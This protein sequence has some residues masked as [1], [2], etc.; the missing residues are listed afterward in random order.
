MVSRMAASEAGAEK[1]PPSRAAAL[2]NPYY[3][4]ELAEREWSKV[5][6]RREFVR[7]N[8]PGDEGAN[9]R[10]P[11]ADCLPPGGGNDY[12]GLALSGG[13]IRSATFC[14]GVCQH[15][16]EAKFLR[17]VDFLSTVSG[18]GF[19]GGFVGAWIHRKG[20]AAVETQLENS[21]S[22][23]VRFLR[24]NG[25]YIAPNGSGDIGVALASYLRGWVALLC[26]L[27][28]MLFTL[29]LAG[30]AAQECL[31]VTLPTTWTSHPLLSID[32][33]GH[34]WISPWWLAPYA[35]VVVWVIPFG[36][37]FWLLGDKPLRLAPVIVGFLVLTA[38]L[39][40]AY[41]GKQ[42]ASWKH[43]LR[44]DL[45]GIA[46]ILLL[47]GATFLWTRSYK[48]KGKVAPKFVAG[49][50]FAV[51]GAALLAFN[52][53]HW[54]W[55]TKGHFFSPALVLRQALRLYAPDLHAPPFETNL[56]W[57]SLTLL[58]YVWTVAFSGAALTN[59]VDLVRRKLTEIMA[60][61]IWVVA[62]F[63]LF[64][65]VDTL[66][67]TLFKFLLQ[68]RDVDWSSFKRL[69]ALAPGASVSLVA[70]LKALRK[71]P[72]ASPVKMGAA[73]PVAL[74]VAVCASLLAIGCAS[75]LSLCAHVLAYR[76]GAV[77]HHS[78]GS[79]NPVDPGAWITLL[80][81]VGVLLLVVLT[82]G[83]TKTLLN[84]SSDLQL[85]TARITRAYLGASNP[86][87]QDN[88]AK[89]N[90]TQPERND[91][92]PF[93]EYHPELKGGP[94]HILN[95]TV[96]ETISGRSN[97]EQKDRHG[98]SM[99]LGPAGITT[100]RVA[101]ALFWSVPFVP[102]L[103]FARRILSTNR[104]REAGRFLSERWSRL[105][106]IL[107]LKGPVFHPLAADPQNPRVHRVEVPTLGG[108][109]GISGAA[110]STGLGQ[111]TSSAYSFLAGFF[112]IRLGYWWDS[113][114][115]PPLR[116]G[117]LPLGFREWLGYTVSEVFF[118]QSY[119]L[120]ELLARFHAPNARRLWNLSDG[121][122]FENTAVYELV[123]RRVSFIIMC[124]CGAD[125]TYTFEDVSN[126]VRKARIDLDAEVTFLDRK[127]LKAVL[128]KDL[129]PLFGHPDDF[130]GA[131]PGHCPY[132]ATLAT[133]DY[134]NE[135]TPRGWL[136]VLKP[137]LHGDEPLDVRDYFTKNP[138]F[139]Q[140]ST[141]D[142]F[143][144][145]AQWEGYRRLGRFIAARVLSAA[146]PAQNSSGA[147]A[148]R[149]AELSR[150][151]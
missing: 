85:Y 65:M 30:S 24:E 138:S 58:G 54:T 121:G 97:L 23:P 92:I 28:L 146:P 128:Q 84:L 73:S 50:G 49:F 14:L 32:H 94:L 43:V 135:G 76:C 139:P 143:F 11:S 18:G 147:R 69:C 17:R 108:W 103:H 116:T 145:E 77:T 26:A 131:T 34:F 78:L 41:M 136:L 81:L 130:A 7:K 63:S 3:P 118:A 20:I 6:D 36:A 44:T 105:K 89:Q 22:Q 144:N 29:T 83:R 104:I 70:A 79:E 21:E 133:I 122:H 19:L 100:G 13:G 106:L 149:P 15:L 75:F 80:E 66:G 47:A 99:A 59:N 102:K 110:F 8:L 115:N 56:A 86:E 27:G 87:R 107:P 9:G 141:M 39:V 48:L 55:Q 31:S 150:P 46:G 93:T 125:P 91:D 4:A 88:P 45:K 72:M 25:R 53:F 109:M 12:V 112:N 74:I 33:F 132:Q 148:W 40:L 127:E 62:G 5:V 51:A 38:F 71:L 111:Q 90:V 57:A 68:G 61:G 95:A 16:A 120:D 98:F 67:G 142:Q 2:A 101:H 35:A 96:N 124:D 37:A 140:E 126:L 10:E 123:R 113:R 1:P 42:P 134:F 129:W 117:P 151:A 137:S 64:A 60:L 82:I 114:I 119:L 52:G